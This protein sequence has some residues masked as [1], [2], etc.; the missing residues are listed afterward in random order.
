MGPNGSA[1]LS[2]GGKKTRFTT[3][4]S[5]SYSHLEWWHFQF[6]GDLVRYKTTF[7]SQ[8]SAIMS[9]QNIL[10]GFGPPINVRYWRKTNMRWDD[11]RAVYGRFWG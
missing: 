1:A 2:E 5:S 4:W 10:K 8:L 7:G 9:H 3:K 6:I 11:E